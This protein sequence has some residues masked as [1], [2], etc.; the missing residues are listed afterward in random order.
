MQ[1]ICKVRGFSQ[2]LANAGL[3]MTTTQK[4]PTLVPNEATGLWATSKEPFPE[5]SEAKQE[6]QSPFLADG[7][8]GSSEQVIGVLFCKLYPKNQIK[9]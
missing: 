9:I 1:H 5:S 6:Q 7:C 2:C 4:I 8:E 3:P